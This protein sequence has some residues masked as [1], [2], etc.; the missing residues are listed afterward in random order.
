[1][2]TYTLIGHLLT[3]SHIHLNLRGVNSVTSLLVLLVGAFF[4]IW[5]FAHYLWITVDNKSFE[6]GT[7]KIHQS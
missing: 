3:L 4:A 7:K 6:H 5:I 2:R 1:W